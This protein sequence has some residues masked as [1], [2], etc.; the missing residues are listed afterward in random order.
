MS[1]ATIIFEDSEEGVKVNTEFSPPFLAG[2][3][4]TMAQRIAIDVFNFVAEEIVNAKEQAAAQQ[5]DDQSPLV[6]PN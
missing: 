3:G 2:D 4:P 6:L 1:R 5:K